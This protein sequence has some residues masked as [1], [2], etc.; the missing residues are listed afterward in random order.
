MSD[1]FKLELVTPEKLAFSEQVTM[2]EIPGEEGDFGVLPGHSPFVSIIRPGIV[3]IHGD[4]VQ[5]IFIAG[6][7]AEVNTSSC[8]ILAEQVIDMNTTSLVEVQTRLSMAHKSLEDAEGD[9]ETAI[10][11]AEVKLCEALVAA[12]AA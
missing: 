5:R 1:T 8:T 7:V 3:T 4:H 9:S 2:V 10:A 6:G 12:M 11:T